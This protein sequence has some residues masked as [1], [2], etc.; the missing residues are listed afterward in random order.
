MSA[1]AKT[2]IGL[3]ILSFHL[4]DAA[5]EA[6]GSGYH[7]NFS[8]LGVMFFYKPLQYSKNSH[9]ALGPR[10]VLLFLLACAA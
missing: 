8:R 10:G 1:Q 5:K 9:S 2:P 4:D 3:P 6:L 7:Q